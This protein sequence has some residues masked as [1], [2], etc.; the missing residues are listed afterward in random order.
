MK[1]RLDL[2]ALA[3]D[4]PVHFMGVGGAGMYPLA[5]LLLRSGGKVSGCDTRGQW[6]HSVISRHWAPRCTSGMTKPTSPRPR[7]SWLQRPS[8]RTIPEILAAKRAGM[9][10]TEA[11]RGAR[12]VGCSGAR[13]GHR[14]HPRKDH[15]NRDDD[16]D[17]RRS[18]HGS[19]GTGRRARNR[20]G[21]E[22]PLRSRRHIRR[23]GG[24]VRPLVS[25]A[26]ARRGGHHQPRSRPPRHL[27]RSR[28]CPETASATSSRACGGAAG[29]SSAQTI[30]EPRR[31]SPRSGPTDTPTGRR[32]APCSARRIFA[33]RRG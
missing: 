11:G 19:H 30:M 6:A 22:P 2:P 21:R 1:A 29:W 12:D 28:R 32:L 7:P 18:R 5:E 26:V 16:R 24:R 3:A 15:D 9:I 14:R 20:M 8:R 25:H 31:C 13:R 4:R 10:V 17:S 23:R 27:R 33:S